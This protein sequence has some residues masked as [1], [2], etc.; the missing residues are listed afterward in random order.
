MQ[1]P[2]SGG[3]SPEA[4]FPSLTAQANSNDT[5]QR[6][7]LNAVKLEPELML[8]TY[9]PRK[10]LN[11][12][13]FVGTGHMVGSKII[14]R[15]SS[16]LRGDPGFQQET[17]QHKGDGGT[18]CFQWE[19][20]IW[21]WRPCKMWMKQPNGDSPEWPRDSFSSSPHKIKNNRI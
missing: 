11:S 2:S 8:K 12:N 1:N 18:A 14:S 20:T 4:S 6:I 9:A 19:D 21:G 7:E 15:G 5:L 3:T 10:L 13:L 16:L 17:T